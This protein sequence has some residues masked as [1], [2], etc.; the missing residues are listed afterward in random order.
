MPPPAALESG[1]RLGPYEI[2]ARIGS[3]GMGEV[4]RAL[5]H[6]LHREV[7]IKVLAQSLAG[8]PVRIARLQREA[9]LLAALNHPHIAALFTVEQSGAMNALVMELVEGETLAERLARGPMPVQEAVPI[10]RQIAEALQAAHAH[11]IVHRDLKPANIKITPARVVKVLDFGVAK[12]ADATQSSMVSPPPVAA[13]RPTITDTGA[14]LGTPAYMSP[15][16]SL[17]HP[18]DNRS[19][20]WAF[21]CVLYEML[22]GR[23][24]FDGE[25]GVAVLYTVLN[26]E[27]DLDAL[28]SQVPQPV[29][30][31]IEHC[32]AKDPRRR[33]A[34]ISTALFVLE[35]ADRLATPLPSVSVLRRLRKRVTPRMAVWIA[36]GLLALLADAV[37][38]WLRTSTAP[39]TPARSVRFEIPAPGLLPAEMFTLSPDG[40]HLAFV[41]EN[42]GVRRVWVRQMDSLEAQSLAGTDG[43]TYPFWSPD[44]ASVGF[45]A[46]GKLKK[47]AAAGG[48][49]QDLCDAITGR[50]AT[51]NSDGVIL[52]SM[53]PTEP[54]FR[55]PAAG[56]TPEAVTEVSAQSGA[57]HR[58]PAFLPDGR[59]FLYHAGG[60]NAD[61]AGVYLGSLDGSPPVRILPDETNALYVPPAAGGMGHLAFRRQDALMVQPFDVRTLT[62]TGEPIAVAGDVPMTEH[63]GFGA[64]SVSW[65]GTLAYRSRPADRELVWTN[66]AGLRTSPITEP[67]SFVGQP[68]ISPDGRTVAIVKHTGPQVDVWLRDLPRDVLSRFTLRSGINR[69]PVW[70]PTGTRLL[71]AFQA[72]GAYSSDIYVKPETGGEEELLVRGGVNAYPLDVSSDGRWVIFQQQGESTGLDLWLVPVDGDRKPMPYLQTPFEETNARFAP[73]LP[74]AT[75]WVAYQSNEAGRTEVYVQAITPGLKFQ[76]SMGGGSQ[77][78]WRS[79]GRELFY[80]SE[81]KLMA[82]PVTMNGSL[83]FG[84]ARELF[85]NAGLVG[86]AVSPD[87]QRFL[88]NVPADRKGVTGSPITVVLGWSAGLPD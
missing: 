48:I 56:G 68:A 9:Q 40:R 14:M 86:Y 52:F 10:A 31:L 73:A 67:G 45:F 20:I 87:G 6:R 59:N 70:F 84:P 75:R 5:D 15:E 37:F 78:M 88:L 28:P 71:F 32:L 83:E 42:D 36:V 65:N 2:I 46:R 61:T 54:I 26:H 44:G 7:A 25:D 55:V 64:F 72:P 23:L 34:D 85:S 18:A 60:D 8:D 13:A 80:Q 79:D 43:A 35:H 29:R 30:A 50:G 47:I 16:Q 51:W 62:L 3:G 38:L 57:G 21:G 12:L 22:T 19:D 27:P 1:A 63:D 58:F 74:G 11:G 33:V 17:G 69:S 82:A 76:V 24:P 53:G 39:A 4:Y 66:R 49:P 77:P 81:Q 41:A